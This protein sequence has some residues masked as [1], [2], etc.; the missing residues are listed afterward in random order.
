MAEERM[1]GE[2]VKVGRQIVLP[3]RK[4]IEIAAGSI[5]TRF[6]RS[7]ITMSSIILAIA[8]LMS[9]WTATSIV[10]AQKRLPRQR[11]ADLERELASLAGDQKAQAEK[12]L[13]ELRKK[14]GQ[15]E[16][17][18]QK[19][20]I[21]LTAAEPGG[22]ADRPLFQIPPSLQAGLDEGSVSQELRA[23]FGGKKVQ[24]SQ[25]EVSLDTDRKGGS[26]VLRD[27][28]NAYAIKKEGDALNVYRSETLGWLGKLLRDVEARDRWLATLALLVCFVGI[29]NA[30]LMSVT[31]RFREIGTM[32][33]LG[34]LDRFIVKLFLIES[35][36]QGIVGTCLGI[37][38]GFVLT[39]LRSLMT[40]D[41]VTEFFPLF[42]I[43]TFAV[44]SFLIG[45]TLS[46]LAAI[47]P[48]HRAAKME[49]V[50]AMR[51]DE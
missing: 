12:A 29:V 48:A 3:W 32:K 7:M 8:F 24:L 23:A 9:I 38:V 18:L 44:F 50:E 47:Y 30:M 1:I 37:A 14:K 46:I 4:A 13:Q 25:D 6:W 19:Q 11:I 31:E 36:F 21:E 26:W 41:Y 15:I 16:V 22:A 51:V 45:S 42:S 49:P 10:G 40:F 33:C 39:F 28:D 2:N 35:S 43:L 5:K 20:G 34:A 17:N 27:G